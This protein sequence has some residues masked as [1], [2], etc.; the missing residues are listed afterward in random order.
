MVV[1]EE[2]EKKK[3]KVKN[4]ERIRKLELYDSERFLFSKDKFVLD[5]FFQ[6]K[7]YFLC[8]FIQN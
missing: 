1:V 4:S 7:T 6:K 2:M 5:S 8:L 3:K